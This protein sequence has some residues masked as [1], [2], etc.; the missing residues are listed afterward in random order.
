MFIYF[1]TRYTLFISSKEVEKKRRMEEAVV[2]R[3]R[4]SR[5]AMKE[6]EKEEERAATRKRLEEEEK[7]SRARRLEA[8]QQREHA[9]RLRRENAREQRR[10]ERELQEQQEARE[11]DSR[12]GRC[13]CFMFHVLIAACRPDAST[14]IVQEETSTNPLPTGQSRAA[15][16]L[17]AVPI[18]GTGS[19]SRTPVENWELDCEICGRK[20]INQ[21]SF[22][23]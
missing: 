12:F 5:I 17:S 2:H 10:K 7:M 16:T 6:I 19:G 13:S 15:V 3:K 21:V 4:S 1:Q 9:E 14:D 11:A 18:N 8:R 23:S 22:Y 20:G